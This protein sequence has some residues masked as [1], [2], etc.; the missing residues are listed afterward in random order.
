MKLEKYIA[1]ILCLIFIVYGYEAFFRMDELLPP[2]LK[3]NPVW[4]STFPKILAIFG[5]FVSIFILLNIEKKEDSSSEPLDYKQIIFH[6]YFKVTLLI[7]GMVLYALNLRFLGFVLSSCLFLSFSSFLLGERN[8]IKCLII[9]LIS[10]IS[11]WY[12]V[13]EVLGIYMN[14]Y[15]L[16]L[17]A[18]I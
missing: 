12:L 8:F 1:L 9:I 14:P 18:F 15:P 6:N 2:I 7:L 13:N 11:I 16:F 4:P 17:K 10:T 5:F 3:R